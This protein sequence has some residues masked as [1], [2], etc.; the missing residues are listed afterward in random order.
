MEETLV[1]EKTDD[2]GAD[3]ADGAR[4]ILFNDDYHSF[5]EVIHQLIK[6]ISCSFEQAEKFANTVHHEG[7]C[8]VYHGSME[9]CLHV[10]AVLEEIELK[11]AVDFS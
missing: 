3:T 4:V 7:K 8:E 1:V 11:T 2:T 5:D 9:E 6:A 10:S